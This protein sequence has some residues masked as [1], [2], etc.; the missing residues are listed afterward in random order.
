[1]PDSARIR[2][3]PGYFL[4]FV[5]AMV[6]IG[7]F[8]IDTYLP[9]MPSMAIGFD[10]DIVVINGTMSVYLLGFALGQLFGGPISDQIGRRWIGISGLIVFS[11]ASLLIAAADTIWEVMLGRTLQALGGGFATVICMAMVRDAFDPV[12]AAKRF[13]TVMLVMLGAPLVAPGIGA[14]LLSF[15][16]QSIFIFL[17][18]YGVVVLIAFLP[19][20]ETA[21]HASGKLALGRI[22]PQYIAVVTTKVGGR[23]IPLR[24]IFTQ[25]LLM[26]GTFVFI[27]NS[28]FIYQEYFGVS[29][30]N[31]VFFFGVNILVMILFTLTTSRLIHRVGPYRLWRSAR[32]IQLSALLAL[33]MVVSFSRPHLW[34]FTPLLAVAIGA[35]GMTNPSVSG[36]YLAYFD[37]LSGSAVS[38]MNVTVFLFGAL[39]GAASGLFYDG[40]LRPVVYTMVVA[41]C[42]ANAI[43]LTIPAPKSFVDAP[44]P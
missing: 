25:G 35:G 11:I 37:R 9:A 16:W 18:L 8:A 23:H 32:W 34:T 40:T 15:G 43:A 6:A 22:L 21:V 38:I 30:G 10:T 44:T 4:F 41:A 39:L 7:P 2:G 27:T 33:L 19:V 28:S 17:A 14:I 12:E 31:F 1:V 36:L 3:L 20:P 5:S 24:Y 13:P 42:I 29:A 26:S